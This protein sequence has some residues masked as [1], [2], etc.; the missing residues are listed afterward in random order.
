MFMLYVSLLVAFYTNSLLPDL[1][2]HCTRI[3]CCKFGV[4]S[5]RLPLLSLLAT[6]M[7]MT[8]CAF[9]V[10]SF[11]PVV[12][13]TCKRHAVHLAWLLSCTLVVVTTC[14]LH[15]PRV[16]SILLII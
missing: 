12:V 2:V 4:V 8:F 6:C 13:A 1:L 14:T 11:T 10:A 3:I 7:C 5:H 16:R 15:T 9:G